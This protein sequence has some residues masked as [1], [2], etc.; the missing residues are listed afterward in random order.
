M[1]IRY[2]ERYLEDLYETGRTDDKS[3][4][5][6][7]DIVRR[8]RKCVEAL[9]NAPHV[10]AL[11]AKRALNFKELSGDRRGECSIRVND[12]YRV[13]FTVTL[14]GEDPVITVCNILK[15]SNHYD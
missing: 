3:H 11:L 2:K 9:V 7:P 15:L 12:Q 5:F 6:Q 13:S 14:E 4:R 1:K 10:K 8:Y